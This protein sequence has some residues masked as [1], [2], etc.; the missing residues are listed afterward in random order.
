MVRETHSCTIIMCRC[1]KLDLTVNFGNSAYKLK[2]KGLDGWSS[3]Y[4]VL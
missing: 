3:F 4:I 2:D 1:L